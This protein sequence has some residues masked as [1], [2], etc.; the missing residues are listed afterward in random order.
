MDKESIGEIRGIAEGQNIESNMDSALEEKLKEFPDGKLYQKKVHDM[1]MLTQIY[2]NNGKRELTKNELKFLYEIDDKISGFGYRNDPRIKEIIEKRDKRTDLTIALDCKPN[3]IGIGISE[4]FNNKLV[5]YEG[6]ID[7]ESYRKLKKLNFDLPEYLS[8]SLILYLFEPIDELD[9]LVFPKSISDAFYLWLSKPSDDLNLILPKNIGGNFNLIGL[10]SPRNLILPQNI[11]HDL[12]LNYFESAEGVIL[13]KNMSGSVDLNN[14]TSAK[15]LVLPTTIGGDL[16]L[17]SLF[18]TE[19]LVLPQSIG[20]SLYLSGLITAEGLVF[21]EKIGGDLDLC[22]LHNGKNLK[23][24]KNI[25]G[26]L[27]LSNLSSLKDLIL[28]ETIGGTVTYNKYYIYT[29]K[30]LKQ[31]QQEEINKESI[32]SNHRGFVTGIFTIIFALF[33]TIFS[34]LISIFIIK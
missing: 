14:L 7:S 18:S 9:E 3:E 6:D 34:I 32:N 25:G 16:Y 27:Y 22:G 23:L 24:P 2:D 19:G 33:I 4:L 13:P 26:D 8:G 12:I 17:R 20:G 5:Y 21:P 11:G 28:P 1:K 15:G 10:K 30:E 31:L 29:L